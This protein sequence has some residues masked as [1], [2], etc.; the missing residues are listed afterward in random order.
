MC[1]DMFYTTFGLRS[2]CTPAR[3]SS[4][5]SSSLIGIL[6]STELGG[7]LQG[8]L[9]LVCGGLGLGNAVICRFHD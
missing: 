1:L 3:Q 2:I 4:A 5:S 7:R 8:S 9:G 6:S